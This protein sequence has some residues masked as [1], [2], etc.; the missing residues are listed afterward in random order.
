MGTDDVRAV[1][2]EQLPDLRVQTIDFLGEGQENVAY[3]VNGT[4]IVRFAKDIA[5]Q[6][7]EPALLATVAGFSTLPIPRTRFF[8]P[9]LGCLAY[10]KLPG[11][12]LIDLAIRPPMVAEVLTTFLT[13]VQAIPVERIAGLVGVDDDPPE[14]W[15]AEAR[16]SYAAV[17]VPDRHRPAIERFLATPPH[18]RDYEPVFSHNDLGIEHVLIDQDTG[19][20]TGVID[21]SDAAICDPAYD[22]GLIFRDLGVLGPYPDRARFYARCSL[23]ED[24]A[25]GIEFA[26]PSFVDKSIESLRWVFG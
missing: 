5:R 22:Y 1:L 14:Q 11:V 8:V 17:E 7:D 25:Y 12:P 3:E 21:W 24:L 18:H 19:A 10:D 4:L 20:V 15:L 26:K 6:G 16:E 9:E 13:A 2:A 23:L